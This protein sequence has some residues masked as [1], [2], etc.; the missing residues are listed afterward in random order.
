MK[1]ITF[2]LSSRRSLR[3]NKQIAIFSLLLLTAC[4]NDDSGSYTPIQTDY[5]ITT[6]QSSIQWY[7]NLLNIIKHKGLLDIRHGNI[8][9]SEDQIVGGRIVIDMSTIQPTIDESLPDE[10]L[11]ELLKE[12]LTSEDFFNLEKHP[13]AVFDIHGSTNEYIFGELNLHGVSR[14]DTI[15]NLQLYIEDER[16][17]GS[18]NLNFSGDDYDLAYKHESR[19]MIVSFIVDTD[20]KIIGKLPA[21]KVLVQK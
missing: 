3:M 17:T 16:I 15:N 14:L 12:H 10:N 4:I 9:V 13:T 6:E 2:E 5:E 21:K 20:L 19:D 1:S 7:G 8:I 18:G 11:T